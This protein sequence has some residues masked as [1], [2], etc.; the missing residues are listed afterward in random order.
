MARPDGPGNASR[1]RLGRL[2]NNPAKRN[3]FVSL[4]RFA[5]VSQYLSKKSVLAKEVAMKMVGNNN[6]GVRVS[7]PKTG[8]ELAGTGALVFEGE[9]IEAGKELPA[10]EQNHR[11]FFRTMTV[12][13]AIFHPVEAL[14]RAIAW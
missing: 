9:I 2:A 10:W 13:E 1:A 3:Y 5:T 7:G 4:L 8:Q 11:I 6:L 14:K 12:V